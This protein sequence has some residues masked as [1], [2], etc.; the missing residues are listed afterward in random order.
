MFRNRILRSLC[1]LVLGVLLTMYSADAPLIL[2]QATGAL[3]VLSGLISLLSLLRKHRTRQE[4]LLYP[5]LGV[6][7]IVMGTLLIAMPA[8][9]LTAFMYVIAALLVLAGAFQFLSCLR[10]RQT[11]IRLHAV[12]CVVPVLEFGAGLFVLVHPLAT[13]SLPFVVMGVAYV[14][15]ALM[16]GWAA[17]Q[18]RRYEKAHPVQEAEEVVEPADILPHEDAE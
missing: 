16:E 15:Y 5:I 11:G 1:I 14:V 12:A 8:F 3:L 13:A 9:F 17:V 6:A 2:V 18:V 7:T 10:M 4:T